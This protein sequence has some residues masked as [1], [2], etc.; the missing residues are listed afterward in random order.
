[1]YEIKR[2]PLKLAPDGLRAAG[3]QGTGCK[4]QTSVVR[5]GRAASSE[6][7]TSSGIVSFG[8]LILIVGKVPPFSHSSLGLRKDIRRSLMRFNI[9]NYSRN[10]LPLGH[11]DHQPCPHSLPSSNPL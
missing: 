4:A 10:P 6:W 11:I 9:T 3:P 2:S 1:M 8:S 7:T 5:R